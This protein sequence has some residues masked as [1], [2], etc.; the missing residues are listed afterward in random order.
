MEKLRDI[1]QGVG[2]VEKNNGPLAEPVV[3]QDLFARA[4]ELIDL[5]TKGDSN[6]TYAD[7]SSVIGQVEAVNGFYADE[8]RRWVPLGLEN[9]I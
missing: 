7:V 4:N 2:V 5:W 6:V 1:S 8:L 3:E 9:R